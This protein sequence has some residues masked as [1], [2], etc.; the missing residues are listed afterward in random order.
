MVFHV[1]G[2]RF[3]I[4]IVPRGILVFLAVHHDGVVT[5]LTLPGQL[6]VV[7]LGLRYSRLTDSSGK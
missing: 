2:C 6:E 4:R 5:R 1:A 7:E 3:G